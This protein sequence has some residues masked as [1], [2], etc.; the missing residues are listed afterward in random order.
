MND[1]GRDRYLEET[2]AESA[3][4]ERAEILDARADALTEALF[5]AP[6]ACPVTGV[7]LG[8]V[9]GSLDDYAAFDTLVF[10]CA[11]GNSAA[12]SMLNAQL[13]RTAKKL[14]LEQL[15]RTEELRGAA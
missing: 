5:T 14:I 2:P 4:R 13:A 7:T 6:D 9:I 15:E 12:P 3:E 1:Y 11:G 8:D 10:A